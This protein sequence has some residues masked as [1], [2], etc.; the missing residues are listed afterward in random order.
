MIMC[1]QPDA[2]GSHAEV[3]RRA[4]R[5]VA[6]RAQLD[7]GT[8]CRERGRLAEPHRRYR[9][10]DAE[11]G[12]LEFRATRSG[13]RRDS[14]RTVPGTTFLG[15]KS[16]VS[17]GAGASRLGC[18]EFLVGQASRRNHFGSL[19]EAPAVVVLPLV[20]AERL[21][22]NVRAEVERLH[23]NVRAGEGALPSAQKFSTP[24]QWTSPRTYST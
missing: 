24:L 13:T 8:T 10:R 9:T 12:R 15:V 11:H 3:D 4:S 1:N 20:E 17:H 7:S 21:F 23:G 22:V 5:E 18:Y 16:S 19:Q 2:K 14:L 6:A